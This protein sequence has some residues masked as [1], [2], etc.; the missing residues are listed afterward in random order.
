MVLRV[1]PEGASTTGAIMA[2]FDVEIT[3]TT[4]V[5]D[6][7]SRARRYTRAKTAD[8]S[9]D[10]DI[11]VTR[12]GEVEFKSDK[13]QGGHPAKTIVIAFEKNDGWQSF[14]YLMSE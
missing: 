10:K 14:E 6:G 3:V 5:T 4:V 11:V 12:N 8:E 9:A 7:N 1:R 13:L 2:G